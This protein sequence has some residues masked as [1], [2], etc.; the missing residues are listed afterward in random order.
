MRD[1]THSLPEPLARLSALAL[2][3]HWAWNHAGDG[4]WKQLDET[5]WERTQNPW[6]MLQ[7]VPV[8]RVERLASDPSFLRDVQALWESRE[9]YRTTPPWRPPGTATLPGV[10]YFSME[11]GL[12]EALPLYA[13]GLGILAGD[14]LKTA[15]DL[16]VPVIGIGILW[17]QGYFRQVLDADGRQTELYPFN[18]PAS[19]PVQPVVSANGDRLRISL[20]FPG[21]TILLR[22]WQVTVGRTTLY[23]LD[24]NDPFNTP[25]DRGLTSALYGGSSEVRLLQEI[26]LGVGGWRLVSA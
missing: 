25:A 3:L 5:L 17:Q 21:R 9:R 23:L 7:Y 14:Y 8:E 19:L 2:D 16:D 6:L 24:S 4:V 13:G 26:I 20:T 22:A 15:S 12:H 18:E 11:F 1:S 10:A